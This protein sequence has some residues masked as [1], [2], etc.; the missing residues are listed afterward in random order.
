MS[1]SCQCCADGYPDLEAHDKSGLHFASLSCERRAVQLSGYF[2][3]DCGLVLSHQFSQTAGERL[4]RSIAAHRHHI[5]A[6]RSRY[7]RSLTRKRVACPASKPVTPLNVH[8]MAGVFLSMTA[9]V[10]AAAGL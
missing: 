2:R 4:N 7:E 9:G 1:W 3:W 10:L 5:E 6:I 8:Q